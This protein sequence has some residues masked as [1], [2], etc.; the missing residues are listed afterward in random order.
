MIKHER[1][2]LLAGIACA[3]GVAAAT[4]AWEIPSAQANVTCEIHRKN[5]ALPEGEK[6]RFVARA[7]I[8]HVE[9]TWDI[10]AR[11]KPIEDV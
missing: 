7:L 2:R 8:A 3:V 6:S 11:E 5:S 4:Y 10:V 1:A 9:K